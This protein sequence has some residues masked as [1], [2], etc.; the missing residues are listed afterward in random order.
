MKRYGI[1]DNITSPADLRGLSY[2]TLGVLC[3]SLREF[4]VD[5]VSRTGGHLASNFGVVELAV[6]LE[7]EFDSTRDR[8]IY[9]VGH[10]SYCLL[11]TSRCV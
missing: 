10:Q 7:R 5:S 8:I 4:I 11:Y 2:D 9:D 3:A 6:A 1:L